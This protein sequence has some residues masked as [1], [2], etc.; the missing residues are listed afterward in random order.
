MGY[1]SG[2]RQAFGAA[3]EE[4]AI[5][6]LVTDS[7][8]ADLNTLIE[9]QWEKASGPPKPFL[10]A[11]LLMARVMTGVDL[12]QA[13]PARELAQVAPRPVLLIHYEADDYVP[14]ANLG[15]LQAADP[16]AETRVLPGADCLHSE[17]FNAKPAAY[18]TRIKDFFAD[19]I[20]AKR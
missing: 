13:Q 20:P 19:V 10:Y 15:S 2:Q 14:L 7:G 16:A 11:A 12:T 3:A 4:P 6:G 1:R 5:A 8:F 17:G 18:G 9:E